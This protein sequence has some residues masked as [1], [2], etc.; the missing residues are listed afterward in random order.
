ISPD[1]A[2]GLPA[3]NEFAYGI[4]PTNTLDPLGLETHHARGTWHPPP[5]GGPPVPL[6]NN[7]NL[8]SGFDAPNARSDMMNPAVTTNAA[9]YDARARRR[10]TNA[11]DPETANQSRAAAEATANNRERFSDTEAQAMREVERA[12]P[13]QADRAGG[14]L[15]IQGQLPPCQMCRS[16]MQEFA[17]RNNCT[18]E[19][20]YPL[21]ENPPGLFRSDRGNSTWTEDGQRVAAVRGAGHGAYPTPVV[22]PGGTRPHGYR[23]IADADA[24]LPVPV[25][26]AT[27]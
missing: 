2:A 16:R 20:R 4:S 10:T 21:G 11:G 27:Q 3:L 1:P 5:G 9:D 22:P 8:E 14:R 24:N 6:G 25:P 17:R 12:V 13:N 15:E 23:E 18:V 26:N 7:G 19:Y